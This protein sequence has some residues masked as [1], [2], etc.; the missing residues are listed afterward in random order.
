MSGHATLNWDNERYELGLPETEADKP[1]MQVS[2]KP[3]PVELR[4]TSLSGGGGNQ[5][6]AD[7]VL[8]KAD[9]SYTMQLAATALTQDVQ[10][11]HKVEWQLVLIRRTPPAD[12]SED[13]GTTS[14]D[15][16]RGAP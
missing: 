6:N 13:S 2:A 16:Q 12:S 7:G 4:I 1:R 11:E 15:R 10:Q 5:L 14:E 8:N 9:G 3:L